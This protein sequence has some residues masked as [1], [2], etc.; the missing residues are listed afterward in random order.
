MQKENMAI[1]FANDRSIDIIEQKILSELLSDDQSQ[2]LESLIDFAP[3][4][5]PKYYSHSLRNNSNLSNYSAI[6]DIVDNSLEPKV[7]ATFVKID[8]IQNSDETYKQITITD[9]GVGMDKSTLC[10]ALK[11]GS[12]TGK[13]AFEDLGTYGIGMKHSTLSMGKAFQVFTKNK[14]GNVLVATL[15]T[16]EI[17]TQG[18]KA[19]TIRNANSSEIEWFNGKLNNS[20]CGTIIKIYKLDRI[21]N[22]NLKQ[23]TSTLIKELGLTYMYF[24]NDGS[25][26]I[27]VNNKKVE[28]IDPMGRNLS[29]IEQK[30]EDQFYYPNEYDGSSFKIKV[31]LIGKDYDKCEDSDNLEVDVNSKNSGLWVYRN[32]RLVGRG[33]DLGILTSNDSKKEDIGFKHPSWN[34]IRIEVRTS[35]E[36]DLMLG[37]TNAKIMTERS[38]LFQGLHDKLR[39]LLGPKLNELRNIIK[40]EVKNN[41]NTASDSDM[42]NTID[43]ELKQVDTIPSLLK[44]TQR[45]I[46]LGKN[47]GTTPTTIDSKPDKKTPSNSKPRP[48][49]SHFTKK[50]RWEE[51]DLGTTR[52]KFVDLRTDEFNRPVIVFNTRHVAYAELKKLGTPAISFVTKLCVAMID[53]QN[54]TGYWNS[55]NEHLK[56]NVDYYMEYVWIGLAK[57]IN[58]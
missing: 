13:E 51:E 16:E 49:K 35:G 36:A 20:E 38:V 37:V 33:L 34:R 10:E 12:D 58:G 57:T 56:N 9:N 22:K 3:P 53:A 23:F 27:Y 46:N 32:N 41:P 21:T 39:S 42:K 25:V 44:G 52:E 31:F 19:I 47:P 55:D 2:S 45:Y 5:T 15:D 24:I 18:L 26:S 40:E 30:L 14:T 8:V 17:V 43:H 50:C 7:H 11:L 48:N 54:E 1:E 28:S 4:V 6:C 29:F